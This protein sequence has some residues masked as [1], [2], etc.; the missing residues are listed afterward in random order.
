MFLL[1]AVLLSTVFFA[2]AALQSSTP[3][4]V[5]G[6]TQNVVEISSVITTFNEI[7]GLST[8]ECSGALASRGEKEAC[9]DSIVAYWGNLTREEISVSA[10]CTAGVITFGLTVNSAHE[11]AKYEFEMEALLCL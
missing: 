7:E 10:S 1:G 9:V 4:V 3:F 11:L 2:T 6:S 5:Q 8:S